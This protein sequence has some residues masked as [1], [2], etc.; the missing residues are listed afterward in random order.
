MVKNPETKDPAPVEAKR[1]VEEAWNRGVILATASALPNVIKIKPPLIIEEAE[2]T[3]AL[4]VLADCLKAV[5]P[6]S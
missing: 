6:P 4:G 1:I 3:F 5:F 2:V